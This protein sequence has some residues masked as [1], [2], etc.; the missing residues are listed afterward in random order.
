MAESSKIHTDANEWFSMKKNILLKREKYK[1]IKRNNPISGHGFS[2]FINVDINVIE[3]GIFQPEI[4]RIGYFDWFYIG[5]ATAAAAVVA[6][7][8][9]VG[10]SNLHWYKSDV[11]AINNVKYVGRAL[12]SPPKISG[13]LNNEHV[14][15]R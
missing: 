15:R 10:T 13:C 9:T 8:I 14:H 6:F 1:R 12:D 2:I 7:F 11:I 5:V 3:K 4:Q